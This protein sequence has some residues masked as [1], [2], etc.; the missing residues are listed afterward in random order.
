MAALRRALKYLGPYRRIAAGALVSLL[1]VSLA[2]LISPRILQ[3]G[4]DSGIAKGDLQV[5][6]W[7]ALALVGVAVLRGVFA[8]VQGYGSEVASQGVA[9]DMRNAIYDKL[10]R[11]SFSYH[12]QAQTGQ[13]MTRVTS[14]VEQV[15]QFVGIGSLQFLSALF[16]LVGSAAILLATDWKLAL[17]M[18]AVIPAIF[19]VLG[20]F[21]YRVQPRFKVIQ[22]RVAT[23]N[24]VLQ[25]NLAGARVV[26]AFAA[27]ASEAERYRAANA[28]LVEIWL[29]LVRVFATS[30]PLIFLLYNIGTLIVFWLGGR[31]VLGG[32]MTVGE[33]LAFNLYLSLLLMPIFILAGLATGISRAG[34]SAARL[35][36][37]IDAPIEVADRPDAVDLDQVQG[38]VVF[39]DVHFRYIGAADEVL[40]GVSFTAESGERVAI[41]GVTGSGKSTIINLIPRFYDATAGR[42]LIDGHDVR[43]VTQDSLRRQIGIV[44][45]DPTLFSGTIRE[46]IAFGRPEATDAEVEAAARAAQAED[47]ITELPEGYATVVG[48]RGVGLSGGQRQRIAI[49]RALVVDPRILIFDDSTSAVDTETETR[50]QAALEILLQGRTAFVIAQR[51]STVLHADR[52]L[53]LEE[54]RIAAEGSH[55]TLLASSPIYGEIVAS[56]L[57]DDRAGLPPGLDGRMNGGVSGDGHVDDGIAGEARMNG[58]TRPPVQPNTREV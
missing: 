26:H 25:E 38:R 57:L 8:F 17:A 28:G 27:E 4:I 39:E 33:L 18:L 19:V 36:E 5:I 45:Q 10:Q 7:A 15:Q 32:T 29:G 3:W 30:F 54:G 1:L 34:A 12:D 43:D 16:L 44:L 53:V 9:F 6:A 14:D 42:V 40:R 58:G 55:D 50:I 48:E 41:L 23:L 49:A 37:V 56:Q 13:L 22:E 2:S 35:F 11:L 47:F 46:N 51:L 31:Q 21:I 24:T 52:I 20:T